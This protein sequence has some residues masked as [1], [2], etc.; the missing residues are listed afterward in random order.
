MSTLYESLIRL[1]E[2]GNKLKDD[3]ISE[4]IGN[5]YFK[6]L[7]DTLVKYTDKLYKFIN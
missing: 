7:L 3:I 2:A 5:K 1:N 6:W 4:V